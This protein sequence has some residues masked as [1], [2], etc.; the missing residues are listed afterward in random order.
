MESEIRIKVHSFC[1]LITNSSTTIFVSTHG[2]SIQM[3]KEFVNYLL[4]N[5][6]ST[7]KAEDL[8]T[9]RIDI[10]EDW[11]ADKFEDDEIEVPE[12]LGKK[13]ALLQNSAA[14]DSWRQIQKLKID[15]IREKLDNNEIEVPQ[16][17]EPQR[18]DTLVIIPKNNAKDVKDVTK[19][20]REM[21]SI[22]ESYEG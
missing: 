2:K 4:K 22:E 8:F 9:F 1:D 16:D 17:D 6:G 10:D 12:E 18:E 7:K 13:I 20:V 3:L 21:F 11:M 5:A 14:K 15:F 19:V